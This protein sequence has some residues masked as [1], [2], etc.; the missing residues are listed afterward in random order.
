MLIGEPSSS[1]GDIH[2]QLFGFQIRITPWF[3]FI[4]G[5]LGWGGSQIRDELTGQ[6]RVDPPML[7]SWIVAAFVSILIHELGHAFAFRY[8]G[9]DS[10]IVIYQCGGLAIPHS[11]GSTA[12]AGSPLSQIVISVAGPP[13]SFSPQRY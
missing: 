11:S 12:R 10:H 2:F 1:S 6:M 9:I 7:L 4:V 3:W 5:M 8:Y 13:R